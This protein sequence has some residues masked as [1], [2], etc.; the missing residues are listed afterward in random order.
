MEFSNDE[1]I[2]IN[3]PYKIYGA[4]I[5][6]HVDSF[7]TISEPNKLGQS[8]VGKYI[9]KASPIMF[10]LTRIY[11]KL[12][13][14]IA[15][16]S[17]I[18]EEV[19]L[20]LLLITNI[21]ERQAIDNKL[22]K[23]ML[24]FKG[25]KNY[26]VKYLLNI[27]NNENHRKSKVMEII[28]K[29]KMNIRRNTLGVINI[30]NNFIFQRNIRHGNTENKRNQFLSNNDLY[31]LNKRKNTLE[32]TTDNFKNQSN[33]KHV[34]EL[35]NINSISDSN[36]SISKNEKKNNSNRSFIESIISNNQSINKNITETH[37]NFII[38][39]IK[40]IKKKKYKQ[41]NFSELGIFDAL[42]SKLFF[43]YS[44]K[45]ERRREF[46]NKAEE[47]IYYYF[48]VYNYIQKMQEVDLLVYTLLEDD[49]IKLFEFLSRP[50]LKI[51]PN[52]MDI[53]NEFQQ[54]QSLYIKIGKTEINDLYKSYNKVKLKDDLG[55]EDLKLL[56]L[57]NAEIKFLK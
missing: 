52:R 33:K 40:T 22:I 15:E 34:T 32:I 30:D 23:K 8:I 50:P 49:Q 54:K 28:N 26:D 42:F 38:N 55:F 10:S 2:I 51:T 21:L 5:D 1:N 19:L 43:W 18:L 39:P 24:K 4:T 47:K 29:P 31:Y 12:P 56:R 57:V 16:L 36:S 46:F 7:H 17:G 13:S 53:Y 25:C 14:F 27:F 41:E 35:L 6:N 45:L 11:Q 20:L 3:N 37:K 44:T 48:D 9:L